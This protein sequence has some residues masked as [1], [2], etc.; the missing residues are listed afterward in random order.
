MRVAHYCLDFRPGC[1]LNRRARAV[2][3]SGF[4][5]ESGDSDQVVGSHREKELNADPD[6]SSEPSLAR[7]SDRLGPTED[8]LDLL[9][10]ALTQLV[11]APTRRSP[12]QDRDDPLKLGD[13]R[14]NSFLGQR[15]LKIA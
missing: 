4:Q 8:L 9:P 5:L 7:S 14:E 15:D 1:S 2:L 13:V 11:S 10:L 12:I 6:Q 3:S